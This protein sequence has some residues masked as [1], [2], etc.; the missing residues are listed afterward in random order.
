MRY[1]AARRFRG[2]AHE[3]PRYLY[4]CGNFDEIQGVIADGRAFAGASS[5][6]GE[7][8]KLYGGAWLNGSETWFIGTGRFGG[9][10]GAAV[11]SANVNAAGQPGHGKTPSAG[12]LPI[13]WQYN[14]SRSSRGIPAGEE[15]GRDSAA[16]IRRG[17]RSAD[18]KNPR[19]ILSNDPGM[20]WSIHVSMPPPRSAGSG[21]HVSGRYSDSRFIL[22]PRLPNVFQSVT[23]C[24]FCP[25]LQRRARL[26]FTR[27]SLL[28]LDEEPE[29]Y[30]KGT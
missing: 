3:R 10:A 6:R 7:K 30:G 2:S 22:R 23:H 18:K 17:L 16:V 12:R 5:A 4:Y 9:E 20:P 29:T 19:I 28:I 11:T 26:R 27:S 25:R 15:E 1:S 24:G 13:P 14:R 8:K 21:C